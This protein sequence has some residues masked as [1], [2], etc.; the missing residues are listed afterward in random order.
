MTVFDGSTTAPSA[1]TGPPT[2][3]P[4]PEV[5]GAD[6]GMSALDQLRA[7]V[8]EATAVREVWVHEIERTGV[9]L[10]CDTNIEA[11]LHQKWIS[12]SLP[13]QSRRSRGGSP[14]VTKLRRDLLSARA[15]VDTCVLVEMKGSDGAYREVKN[16]NT[17]EPLLLE[18]S[19]FLTA[20]GVPDP[21][22][23]VRK[24]FVRD[25]DL[26]NAGEALLDAAGLMGGG[27]EDES[28]PT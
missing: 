9:R 11:A 5:E 4:E 3:G 16:P 28:D 15:I 14:D 1:I 19:Y 20:F 26:M 25:A 21:I 12:G 18:D 27:D 17:G 24:L 13:R 7:R 23:L 6:L 22:E 8:T 2:S 10:T